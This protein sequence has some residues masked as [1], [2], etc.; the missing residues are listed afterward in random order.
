MLASQRDYMILPK[1][2]I[3]K[4]YTDIAKFAGHNAVI[5]MPLYYV[6]GIVTCACCVSISC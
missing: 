4:K 1:Y 6:Y 2:G 3:Y 5:W